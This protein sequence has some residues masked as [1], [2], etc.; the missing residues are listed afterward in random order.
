MGQKLES[1]EKRTLRLEALE[2]R[3][4]QRMEKSDEMVKTTNKEDRRKEKSNK[5]NLSLAKKWIGHVLRKGP[6]EGKM[7]G[8]AKNVQ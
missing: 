2:V 3:I 8:K 5:H 6:L 1:L 4:W 7:E